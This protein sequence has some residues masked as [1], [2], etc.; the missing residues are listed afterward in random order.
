MKEN[1]SHYKQAQDWFYDRYLAR[2]VEAKRY[3]VLCYLLAAL[4]GFSLIAW[5]V[6]L[7]FKRTIME[8]YVVL[9]DD[10]NGITATLTAAKSIDLSEH[11]PVMRYFLAKYVQAYESYNSGMSG[12]QFELIRAFSS[13]KTF[14]DFKNE[15]ENDRTEIAVE[16]LSVTFPTIDVAHVRYIAQEQTWLATLKLA[17]V[18]EVDDSLAV[19]NPLGIVVTDYKTIRESNHESR[20]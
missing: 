13:P 19:L 4:L 16:I 5:I 10:I 12:T 11:I 14:M 18:T 15:W 3:Y 2:E 7:P 9:I 17:Q 8:P 6:L 20:N 1:A